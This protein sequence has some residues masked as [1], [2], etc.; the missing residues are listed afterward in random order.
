M[1]IFIVVNVTIFVVFVDVDIVIIR[2]VIVVLI[3]VVGGN[4]YTPPESTP[5]NYVAY[6][7]GVRDKIVMDG[8]INEKAWTD[9]AFTEP[10]IDISTNVAPRF[11]TKAKMR[12]DDT[13]LYVGAYLQEPQI[14]AT[15]TRRNSVIF[16][17][18][19]F[20]IFIDP[21]ASTH[22]YKEFEMNAFNTIWT[23]QMLNKPYMNGGSPTNELYP[24]KSAVFINGTLND[25]AAVNYWWTVEVAIPFTS[26]IQNCSV[27]TAPPS[28][29][30]IWRINFSRVEYRVAIVNNTYVKDNSAPDNWVWTSQHTIN[31]HAPERW[32]FVQF[33]DSAVNSTNFVQNDQ[34]NIRICLAQVFYAE[35]LFMS[36][37]GYFTEDFDLLDVPNDCF[38]GS[39]STSPPNVTVPVNGPY[40]YLATISNAMTTGHIRDDRLIYFD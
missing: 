21:D 4:R 22:F 26:Y 27:A 15:Q 3:A 23:L 1:F 18:N 39:L 16:V 17:D 7:L 40:S 11:L 14:W 32:G 36:V 13:Y 2:V 25:P 24:V 33:A 29:G 37:N 19:D 9:V 6:K 10:F 8:R 28:L 20:E 30:D 35:A 38:D 12:W 5:R 34:W 31:M